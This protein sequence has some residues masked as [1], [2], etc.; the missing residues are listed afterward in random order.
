MFGGAANGVEKS[1][2]D[3]PGP[4]PAQSFEPAGE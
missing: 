3:R 2:G 4:H 1:G